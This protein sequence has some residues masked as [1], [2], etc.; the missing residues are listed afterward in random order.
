MF[1]N[2]TRRQI[3]NK[4]KKEEKDHPK[5]V[6]EAL[7]NRQPI[8]DK[9]YQYILGQ[10]KDKA[11]A[12]ARAKKRNGSQSNIEERAGDAEEKEAEDTPTRA[13]TTTSI[14]YTTSTTTAL[15]TRTTRSG[16]E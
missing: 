14:A 1:P 11:S 2:R 4:F 16:T 12:E 7:T 8:D 13:A 6:D 10:A 5:R 9:W 3:R 15:S